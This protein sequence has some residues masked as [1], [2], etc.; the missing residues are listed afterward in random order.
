MNWVG[1]EPLCALITGARC[2]DPRT[3]LDQLADVLVVDSCIA[4]VGAVGSLTAPSEASIINAEGL[5]V[6]PAFTDPHVH[7][8]TPGQEHKESLATGTRSAAAGGYCQLLAMPNTTPPIDSP[9]ILRGVFS[10]LAE[11]AVI[12]VG[13]LACITR[14]ME[15]SQLTEMG[16][17]AEIG[18]AGF[19]DDGLPVTDAGVLRRAMAYQRLHGLPIALHEEDPS[20]SAGAPLNEGQISAK[21]GLRGSPGIAE[22]T[23]IERDCAIA[24]LESAQ[25][26]VQHLSA[27]RSVDA[28]ARAKQSGVSVTAEASPHH[29]L[30]TEAACDTLD[31]R[32][33]MN[34]PLR[35]EEDRLALIAGLRDGII[36]C[37]ATD[38]A[39]HSKDE[40]SEPF[41][42]APFGTTGLETAFAVLNQE[43][44][45]NRDLD[46]STLIERMTSGCVPFGLEPPM[47]KQG[48]PANLVVFDPEESW[49]A[50]ED[51]WES[52]SENCCFTG[53]SIQGRVVM[54]IASGVLVHRS[55]RL[56]GGEQL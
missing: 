37:V 1:G 21:R 52:R 51:G 29:L 10:R 20:L 43:L 8:R 3:E 31:T 56:S 53:R 23:M 46:L 48:E 34:P 35:F 5:I 47:I 55:G 9:E 18:V 33:K 17:M 14:G 4:E 6:M 36:D 22:S 49:I 19:T 12:P 38:H 13:Q 2:I 54:T 11:E 44:V 27:A 7:L 26:H 32:A 45:G 42:I 50:G 28:I 30:L 16:L 24:D 15:G 40:K 39:P 25:I 41:E